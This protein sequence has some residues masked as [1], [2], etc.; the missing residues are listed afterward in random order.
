MSIIRLTVLI[1]LDDK[2]WNLK[3]EKHQ[4]K[5]SFDHHYNILSKNKKFVNCVLVFHLIV[6]DILI[7][8]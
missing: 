2:I 8:K 1:W 3:N 5:L 7:N 4:N 6:L